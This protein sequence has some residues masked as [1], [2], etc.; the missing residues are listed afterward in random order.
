MTHASISLLVIAACATTGDG[1]RADARNPDPWVVDR[2]CEP[3]SFP[4]LVAQFGPGETRAVLGRGMVR[5]RVRDRCNAITGC[6][7][8]R[9]P[10]GAS[11]VTLT[12][13]VVEPEIVL[14]VSGSISADV[15]APGW[16]HLVCSDGRFHFVTTLEGTPLQQVAIYG[17]LW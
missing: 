12:A 9:E 5:E 17:R 14:S 10:D 6:P 13:T 16:D 2:T 1:D 11:A 3:M 7:P 15:V 8:W 4:Q